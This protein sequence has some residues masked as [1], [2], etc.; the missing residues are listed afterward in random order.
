VQEE[1]NKTYRLMNGVRILCFFSEEE[2]LVS[3]YFLSTD[4]DGRCSSSNLPSERYI[5]ETSFC[6]RIRST[7][8]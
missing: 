2:K 3:K 6:V 8:R 1:D 7:L 4:T 5:S